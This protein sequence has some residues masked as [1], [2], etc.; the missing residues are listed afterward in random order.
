VDKLVRV[1]RRDGTATWLL[2]HIEI[3]RQ[4]D[5]DFPERMFCYVRG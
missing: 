1:V 3:Q 4:Y 2:I 5:R